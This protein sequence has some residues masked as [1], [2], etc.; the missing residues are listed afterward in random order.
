MQKKTESYLAVYDVI[1][2]GLIIKSSKIFF[3]LQI[4]GQKVRIIKI[5][6]DKMIKKFKI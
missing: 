6:A 4:C 2:F 1:L 5:L 3:E